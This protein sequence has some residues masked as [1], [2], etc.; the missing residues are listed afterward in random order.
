MDWN[1]VELSP[2]GLKDWLGGV[3]LIPDEEGRVPELMGG[4]LS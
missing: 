1:Y 4:I 3:R 2:R